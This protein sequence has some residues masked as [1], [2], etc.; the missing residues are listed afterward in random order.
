MH[1]THPKCLALHDGI[2]E[3][4]CIEAAILF[5]LLKESKLARRANWLQDCRIQ[6]KRRRRMKKG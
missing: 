4:Q 1:A 6:K 5:H 3:L 2:K